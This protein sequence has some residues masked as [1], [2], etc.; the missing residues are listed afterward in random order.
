MLVKEHILP[1]SR[2]LSTHLNSLAQQLC[3]IAS[4]AVSSSSNP[5]IPDLPATAQDQKA[6]VAAATDAL[7]AQRT[8]LADLTAAVLEAQARLMEVVVRMLEQTVHGSVARAVRAK[9]EHLAA[10]A[11]GLELKL[12][13]VFFS[14]VFACPFFCG[15]WAG[16]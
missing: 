5:S 13:F 7:A 3:R 14:L 1:I 9:A 2:A 15:R 10:V 11:K 4:P 12:R 8:A 6:A 16:R